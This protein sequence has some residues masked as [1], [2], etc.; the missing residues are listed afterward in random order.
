MENCVLEK[1]L[2][3]EEML[4]KRAKV[5]FKVNGS[6]VWYTTTVVNVKEDEVVL[7]FPEMFA[8]LDVILGNT[9]SCRFYYEDCEYG[10]DASIESIRVYFPQSIALKVTSN[11]TK[12]ENARQAPREDTLF[13]ANVFSRGSEEA[14]Y[15]CVR[16]VSDTGLKVMSKHH[17]SEGEEVV[18]HISLPIRNIFDSVV[19]LKGK[20]MWAKEVENCHECGIEITSMSELYEERLK[21]FLNMYAK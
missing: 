16:D 6:N 17:I 3:L 4:A 13:L 5:K 1:E 19:K 18:V 15:A 14:M 11:I 21:Q 9:I 10:I 7:A 2:I 8:A 20:V 12:F